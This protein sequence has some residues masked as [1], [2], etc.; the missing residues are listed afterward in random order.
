M[1]V[2]TVC[3]RTIVYARLLA[4]EMNLQTGDRIY[5]SFKATGVHVIKG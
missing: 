4:E 2:T 3:N 5:A 1:N